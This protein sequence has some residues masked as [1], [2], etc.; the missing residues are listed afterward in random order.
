MAKRLANAPNMNL[1]ILPTRD[2]DLRPLWVQEHV[3]GLVE[4]AVELS[5]AAEVT[6]AASDAR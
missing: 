2:H 4:E 5:S 3:L 6:V 1:V